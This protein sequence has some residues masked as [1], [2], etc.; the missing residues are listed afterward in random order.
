MRIAHLKIALFVLVLVAPVAVLLLYG[1]VESYGRE[2]PEFPA[3]DKMLRGK[4]GRMDQFGDAVLQR[5]ELTK[6]AIEFRSWVAYRL[7]GFV[8]TTQI[9]S[10]EDGWLFYRP[11]FTDARCIDEA[12]AAAALRRLAV[13]VD[14]GRAAGIDLFVSIAPDKSTI[15]PEM[16][17][18]RM[19]GYW[20]CREQN[21]ATLRRLMKRWM[22]EM[23]DHAEALRAEKAAHPERPLYYFGDTH[24]SPYGAAIALRQLL[25]A[26]FPDRPIAAPQ[27]T[28][29]TRGHRADLSKM[30]LLALEE[31]VATLDP[32]I[33]NDLATLN[34]DPDGY[35][36]VIAHDSFYAMLM[37][38]LRAVFPDVRTFHFVQDSGELGP[39]TLSANRLI[40]NVLEQTLLPR[41]L[42]SHLNWNTPMMMA[43]I[44]RS[45]IA[46][47]ACRNFTAAGAGSRL[48][49]EDS[50]VSIDLPAAQPAR[51]PCLRLTLAKPVASLLEVMLPDPQDG[52]FEPG[53][54]F[55]Y[56]LAADKRVVS[57]VLPAYVAGGGIRLALSAAARPIALQ[58]IEIGD[59]DWAD[60]ETADR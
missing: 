48:G 44:K 26:V 57:F 28:G 50:P 41:I 4:K 11:E 42:D 18:Q 23:I 55:L 45:T 27:P 1:A 51:L 9:V 59:V 15:Y 14:M 19:R 47:K 8:D 24:W 30:L 52:A 49:G 53:H 31:Q 3:I 2:H 12:S 58:A 38:Q 39:P 33:E 60:I 56:R 6:L 7:V 54:G 36:T 40:I 35:R 29:E 37:P 25:V 43:I 46:A 10:G 16:L 20:R 17:N 13:L 22:P 34:R 21:I 5:S 32:A